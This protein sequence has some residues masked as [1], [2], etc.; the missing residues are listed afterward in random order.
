MDKALGEY[1]RLTNFSVP[2][3]LVAARTELEGHLLWVA[4]RAQ[5]AIEKLEEASV[6]E[7]QLRYTEP[8]WYPRPVAEVLKRLHPES[9][10]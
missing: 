7:R 5:Q 9:G 3:E 10:S 6:K 8:T 4:G 1:L 2:E